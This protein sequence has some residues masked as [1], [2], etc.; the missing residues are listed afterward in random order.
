MRHHPDNQR[1]PCLRCRKSPRTCYCHL[2]RPFRSSTQFVIL[3]HPKERR[4]AIGTARMVH[5]S[6]EGSELRV[7]K[8]FD[9]DPVVSQY[10]KD[11]S[12]HCVVLFPSERS[13][14][15]STAREAGEL[16]RWIPP[17]KNLVVFVLDG[18]WTQAKRILERSLK[19]ARLPQVCFT[20]REKSQYRIRQQPEDYCLSTLEAVTEVLN[21]LE[22]GAPVENLTQ[23]FHSMVET[24]LGFSA[25]VKAPASIPS[26]APAAL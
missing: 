16:D 4:K 13:A 11:E 21:I 1:I 20:V 8:E 22:T 10:L 26:P 6:M 15:L 2:L 3:Q 14:N 19:L 12:R 17:G 5:L 9:D 25:Y 24:Q 18:T 23:V 7:G